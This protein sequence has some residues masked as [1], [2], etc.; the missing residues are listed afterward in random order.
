MTP[1]QRILVNTIATYGRTLLAVFL[2]LFSSRWTLSALGEIDYGLMG[3]VGSVLVFITLLNALTTAANARFFAFSIGQADLIMTR[4]WFN[5]A[6]S[7]SLLL[8]TILLLAGLFVGE[9]VIQHYLS[10]PAERLVTSLWVFRL[11]LLTAYVTMLCAPFLAMFTAKQNI[12]ELSIWGMAVSVTTFVF[13]YFLADI[14]GDKWLIYTIGISSITSFFTIVQAIRASRKYTECKVVLSYWFKGK[15]IKEMFSYS[16]WT[17]FGGLGG[18]LYHNG[19][20]IVLNKFF[21]PSVFPSVN[22]SYTIGHT[23]AGHTQTISSSLSGA[24]MPEIVSS[25][26]RGDRERVINLMF[27]SIRL[28][29]V[30]ISVVVFPI[31]F[32]TETILNIW[33]KNPPEYAVLFCRIMLVAFLI[34]RIVGSFD[35]AI[36]ATGR[37]KNYQITMLSLAFCTIFLAA[38]L[39]YCGLGIYSICGVII[40]YSVI[41]DIVSVYFCKKLVHISIKQ[42]L[43]QVV[44]PISIT[45]VLNVLTGALL[46]YLTSGFGSIARLFTV[47]TAIIVFATV[48]NWIYLTDQDEKI[49]I[50]KMISSVK[51]RIIKR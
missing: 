15:L 19:L 12:A 40:G 43:K 1:G 8:P 39:F 41:F 6:L 46:L 32:Q 31:M 42:W 7:I 2:G 50:K 33:L 22:A 25:E 14:P 10:I 3:V 18:I 38:A 9:Y 35:S 23:V 29:F 5:S 17:L 51:Q 13:V 20:A 11:S 47:V 45:V 21:P 44:R 28:S 27:K 24:F 4:K 37:I 26:G 30:I 49:R 16:F 48:I 34:M 36:C